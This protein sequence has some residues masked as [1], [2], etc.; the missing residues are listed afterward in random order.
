MLGYFVRMMRSM[1]TDAGRG[2]QGRW[3]KKLLY[4]CKVNNVKNLHAFEDS[5]EFFRRVKK[6]QEG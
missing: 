2:I 6:W 1:F 5:F 3:T 4:R